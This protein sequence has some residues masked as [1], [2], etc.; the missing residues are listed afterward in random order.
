[1]GW[2]TVRSRT[3][4]FNGDDRNP[5]IAFLFICCGGAESHVMLSPTI[6]MSLH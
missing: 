3:A 2:A 5:D 4:S 6:P 1:M